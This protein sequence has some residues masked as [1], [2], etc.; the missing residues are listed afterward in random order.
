ML[1]HFLFILIPK[2]ILLPPY[3]RIQ[4]IVRKDKPITT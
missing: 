1:T 2:I 3:D 4:I